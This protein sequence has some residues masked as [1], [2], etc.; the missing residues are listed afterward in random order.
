MFLAVIIGIPAGVFAA[1]KRGS[2]FDQSLM[3]VALVGYSMPIFW[4]GLL[5]IIFCFRLSC[6]GRRSRVASR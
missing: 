1:V 2:W 3:G 4:W 5:L 6:S